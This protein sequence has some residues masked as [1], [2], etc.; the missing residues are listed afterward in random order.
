LIKSFCYD[1]YRTCIVVYPAG[2]LLA[3]GNNYAGPAAAGMVD[4]VTIPDCGVY[5]GTGL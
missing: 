5:T 2:N 4:S 1:F 3:P